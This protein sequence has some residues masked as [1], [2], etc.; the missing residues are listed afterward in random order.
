MSHAHLLGRRGV[1]F[2][3]AAPFLE[4]GSLA[5]LTECGRWD[6]GDDQPRRQDAEDRS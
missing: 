6:G 2:D 4:S 1:T 3:A 5:E